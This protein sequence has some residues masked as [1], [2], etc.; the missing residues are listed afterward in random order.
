MIGSELNEIDVTINGRFLTR[1]IS[2]VERV[3]REFLKEL[4]SRADAHG[5]VHHR[6]NVLQLKIAIPDQAG[7]GAAISSKPFGSIPFAKVSMPW[8]LSSLAAGRSIQGG[9]GHLWE[10][11]ALAY[12]ARGTCLL[13]LANSAPVCHGSQTVFV[14]DAAIYAVPDGYSSS[15]RATYRLMYQ[16]LKWSPSTYVTNSEFSRS[17]LQKYIGLDPRKTSIV[18]LGAQ[19]FRQVEPDFSILERQ[20]LSGSKFLLA[21]SS[22][23]PN[24]NFPRVVEALNALGA[25]APRLAIVGD[26]KHPAFAPLALQSHPKVVPLGRVTDAE[27]AA[28]YRSARGLIYP[29]LYEGFGLPPVEALV[30]GC[31]PLV[32]NRASLPEVCGSD[33][34]YCDPLQI[35]SIARGMRQLLALTDAEYAERLA[36]AQGH[37]HRY[38]WSNG[39][40]QLLDHLI[41]HHRINRFERKAPI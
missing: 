24:K 6:H 35:D 30:S 3:A 21:V 9:L 40:G 39:V 34:L 36:R 18:S 2:G 23:Q 31:L 12:A 11:I 28:L 22:V 29:S 33:V 38:S 8:P 7:D 20:N 4:G 14:H 26:L 32:S 16:L 27:L 17:E 5:R 1:P 41:D 19:Q 10:Q 37:T 15:Y 13:N 25:D